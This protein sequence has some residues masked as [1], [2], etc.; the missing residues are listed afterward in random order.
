MQGAS[1]NSLALKLPKCE[2]FD[3]F[4]RLSV[5]KAAQK[6]T[7]NLQIVCVGFE[8]KIS[9]PFSGFV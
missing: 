8:K 2:I 7:L 9:I 1:R 3:Q 6:T 5:Y 4:L